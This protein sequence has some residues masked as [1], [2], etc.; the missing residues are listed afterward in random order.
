MSPSATN[1]FI[2]VREWR[3]GSACIGRVYWL[4]VPKW[5]TPVIISRFLS[6]RYPDALPGPT[7]CLELQ[8]NGRI[9]MCAWGNDASNSN[10]G[11]FPDNP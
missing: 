10:T 2:P 8:P 5:S 4:I 6:R 1:S 11:A 3:V 9:L 7:S